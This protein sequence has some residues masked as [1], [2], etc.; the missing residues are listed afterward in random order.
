MDKK[1]KAQEKLTR[2][3]ERKLTQGQEPEPVEFESD[4]EEAA[5]DAE[6]PADLD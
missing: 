6:S 4:D 3:A 2:R 5:A 1:L